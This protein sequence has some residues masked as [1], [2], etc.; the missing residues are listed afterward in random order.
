[1]PRHSAYP[2][3]ANPRVEITHHFAGP[4]GAAPAGSTT[5]A[6]ATIDAPTHRATTRDVSLPSNIAAHRT[7]SVPICGHAGASSGIGGSLS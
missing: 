4:N 3:A 2:A 6:E 5:T 7:A 1:M